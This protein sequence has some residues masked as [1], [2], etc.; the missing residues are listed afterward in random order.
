LYGFKKT[1]ITVVDQ[2]NSN[3]SGSELSRKPGFIFKTLVTNLKNRVRLSSDTFKSHRNMF[4]CL[5]VMYGA[6]DEDNSWA[7]LEA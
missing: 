4:I 1:Y 5:G 6:G 3:Y 7:E 2:N